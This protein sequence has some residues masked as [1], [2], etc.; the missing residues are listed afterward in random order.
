MEQEFYSR[1]S[2][3]ALSGGFLTKEDAAAILR[4]EKIDLLLLLNAAYNVRKK[5]FSNQVKIH[6][7][8]N[9]QNGRCSEDCRYCA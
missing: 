5:Y 3:K 8:N 9:V 2:Q 1:L 7:I 6:V 4:S